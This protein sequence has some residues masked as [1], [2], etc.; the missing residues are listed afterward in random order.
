MCTNCVCT[1]FSFLFLVTISGGRH[2]DFLGS[3]TGQ[4]DKQTALLY[5]S[6]PF[7]KQ[8]NKQTNSPTIIFVTSLQTN[9]K[10]CSTIQYSWPIYKKQPCYTI[11]DHFTNKETNRPANLF[12]TITNTNKKNS[13]AILFVT[14]LIQQWG[15]YFCQGDNNNIIIKHWLKKLLK[16][17]VEFWSWQISINIGWFLS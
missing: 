17:S 3:V 7:D 2:Q 15:S 14:I 16:M 9:N 6:W 10:P 5:Y 13:P 12:V 11:C 4:E 1:L 8:T